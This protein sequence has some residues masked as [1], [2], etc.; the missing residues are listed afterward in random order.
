MSPPP[1]RACYYPDP[2]GA[3]V[4]TEVVVDF[5]PETGAEVGVE[6]QT[7]TEVRRKSYRPKCGIYFTTCLTK[8]Q[9]NLLRC[10]LFPT[11]FPTFM[12]VLT[13]YYVIYLR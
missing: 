11:Y 1:S 2:S 8:Y 6:R 5:P 10:D 12:R 7:T 4:K 9:L 3:R 13:L